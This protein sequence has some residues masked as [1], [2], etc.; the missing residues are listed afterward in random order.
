M[1]PGRLRGSR[2]RRDTVLRILRAIWPGLAILGYFGIAVAFCNP[3]HN[4]ALYDDWAY[5][6]NVRRFVERGELR[7]VWTQVPFFGQ[8]LGGALFAKLFGFSFASLHLWSLTLGIL[9]AFAVYVLA[10]EYGRSRSTSLLLAL[11]LA[12]IPGYFH[13]CFTFMTDVPATASFLVFLALFARAERA[14]AQGAPGVVR[15]FVISGIIL[16]MSATIRDFTLFFLV[17]PVLAW[18]VTRRWHRRLLAVGA[19]T[20]L[21]ALSYGIMHTFVDMPYRKTKLVAELLQP[22]SARQA[23]VMTSYLG[24]ALAPVIAS[25]LPD[26]FRRE[27]RGSWRRWLAWGSCLI[28]MAALACYQHGWSVANAPDENSELMPYPPG[29]ISIH[30]IYN[31]LTI[32]GTAAVIMPQPM[33]YGLTFLGVFG[34][35]VLLYAG[36]MLIHRLMSG[37]RENR[38]LRGVVAW[39]SLALGASGVGLA[40]LAPGSMTGSG[41][42]MGSPRPIAEALVLLALASAALFGAMRWK[43][44]PSRAS[45]GVAMYTVLTAGVVAVTLGAFL[46]YLVSA[47]FFTRYT[48]A[49]VPGAFIV[50]LV[51]FRELRP[52][53]PLLVLGI[54]VWTV[55]SIVWTRDRISFNEARWQAGRWLLEQGIPP[56]EIVA[57]FEFDCWHNEFRAPQPSPQHALVGDVWLRPHFVLTLDNFFE[58]Y[59]K[60][61]GSGSGVRYWGS[62]YQPMS[63]PHGPAFLYA[64]ILEGR[65][66]AIQIWRRRDVPLPGNR[67]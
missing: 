25:L 16:A 12:G 37:G 28:L 59:P 62:V 65:Q 34:G 1:A 51:V 55:V 52:N 48:L 14:A 21:S 61:R 50:I 43:R 18:Y 3:L 46:Y 47:K 39:G 11:A 36:G 64:S 13:F 53:R 7:F 33:R 23:Y 30:G 56:D 19:A 6:D 67:G 4:T 9:G 15:L 57:G 49:M 40:V 38:R 20:V 66:R 2:S 35:S 31:R 26:F 44:R 29:F 10:R 45:A 58:S 27:L 8:L 5:A 24:L 17:S 42:V 63:P 22:E 32:A 54:V 41:A 60:A